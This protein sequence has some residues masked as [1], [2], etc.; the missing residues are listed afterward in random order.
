MKIK[1][2]G[3]EITQKIVKPKTV[4]DVNLRN[5][6]EIVIPTEAWQGI[7]NELRQ[8]Y[9]IKWNTTKDLKLT[10]PV[11]IPDKEKKLSKIFIFTLLCGASKGFMRALKAF[12]KS[13]EAPQGSVKIKF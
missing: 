3:N 8:I 2:T 4:P 7:L 5:V 12:I 10:L 9:I 13:F 6:E 1:L 11:T